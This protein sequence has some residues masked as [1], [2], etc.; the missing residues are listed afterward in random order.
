[1][2]ANDPGTD[3]ERRG[4]AAKELARLRPALALDAERC[5]GRAEAVGFLARVDR[6]FADVHVPVEALY[7][8]EVVEG[9]VRGALRA[10][11]VRPAALRALDRRR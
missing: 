6:W 9:L 7:G 3:A 1:M 8:T 10:A 11:A 4:R 2:N 5:L